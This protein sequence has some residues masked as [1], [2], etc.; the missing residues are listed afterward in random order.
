MTII[1]GELCIRGPTVMKEYW[2]KPEATAKDIDRDGWFRTGDVARIDADGF[3]YIMDRVKDLIIRGGE[4]VS[5]AEV[6]SIAYDFPSVGEA[7]AF[8][9]DHPLLGEEVGLAITHAHGT[10]P[11]EAA[12]LLK[13]MAA[14]LAK[15]KV[16]AHVYLWPDERLPRGATGKIPKKDIR[17][18]IK[19][20]TSGVTVLHSLPFKRTSNL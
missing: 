15:F 5:C 1:I 19:L 7:A 20:G 8:G 17:Q 12:E 14:R 16:P 11:V 3:I 10:A 9:V 4:N 6:E 13:F 2:N 18:Q